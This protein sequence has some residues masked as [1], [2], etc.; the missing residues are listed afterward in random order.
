MVIYEITELITSA[1]NIYN[2]YNFVILQIYFF[3]LLRKCAWVRFGGLLCDLVAKININD[4]CCLAKLRVMQP[5]NF[6][7]L[8]FTFLE[9]VKFCFKEVVKNKIYYREP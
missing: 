2:L 5:R 7:A 6:T 4:D 9:K 1:L 3:P 8:P